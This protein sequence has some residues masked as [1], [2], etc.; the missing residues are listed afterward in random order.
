MHLCGSDRDT[1]SLAAGPE[2]RSSEPDL[3]FSIPCMARL[4]EL[5]DLYRV[6]SDAG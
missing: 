2:L 4:D 3:D 1:V 6:T 5:C